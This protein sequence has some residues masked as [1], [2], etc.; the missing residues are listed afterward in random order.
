MA[1]EEDREELRKISTT[2]STPT[3]SFERKYFYLYGF[4]VLYLQ[5]NLSKLL[6]K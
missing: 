1:V 3:V 5:F 4:Y 2:S 6:F